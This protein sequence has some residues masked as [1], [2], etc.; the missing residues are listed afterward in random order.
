MS[1]FFQ[2]A[3]M[4][5]ELSP[6]IKGRVDIDQYYKGMQTAENV[7][8]VP[9][10]GLKRRPGTQH[11]DVAEK[12][13]SP[14]VGT[15][16]ITL[17]NGGTAA[18][19][20]D[21][22]P[23]TQSVTTTPVGNLGTSG[24]SDYVVALYNLSS[25]SSRG[26]FVEIKDIKL[27]GT[28]T[29]VFKL[30]ISTDNVSYSTSKTLTVTE[31]P[32]SIKA[33]VSDTGDVKY[34]RIIRTGDTGN[35]AGLQVS[36]SEFNVLFPT[37]TASIAKTFDLS[38]ESDRHYLGVLT[39]GFDTFNFTITTG[40]P[41]VGNTYTVNSATYRVLSFVSGVAKT[42]RTIGTNAPPT[43]GTLAG[44]PTLTYSAVSHSD[45]FG[46]MSFYRVNDTMKLAPPNSISIT[47]FLTTPFASSEV[48]DVR[49]VQTE[50]VMLMFHMEHFPKRIINT[51]E[52]AFVIDSI[53][54]LNI[55]QFDFNDALS[56][57][58]TAA[59]QV[60]TFPNS[61]TTGVQIGD[62]FQIDVEGVLSKNISFAGDS[63]A[64]EQSSTI[65]NIR[66]NLQDMPI[67]GDDGIVV[68]RTG[69]LEYTITLDG[70]SSGTYEL[71]TGF[72][73]SGK[74]TDAIT[75]TRSA[76]G[77]PRSE[78]VWSDT[79]GYPRTATFFQGRL[80]FGGTKSKR[81]SV[82]A[83]RA[84][85][86]FDFFTEEG[87]D[88]EGIFVTISSRNL[89]EI[90]DINPDRGLQ[91][92]TSGAEFLLTGNTP[93][94]VSIKAQTQH[95]SKFLEAKSLDGAT[96]FID[97]NGK[98]L[99]QYLYNYNE[100][101][102]NSVDI[103]VL[104]SHLIDNP[105]DVGVLSGSTTEDANYVV[106]I[107][108]DGSAAILNTLRSQDINGFT[109]WTNGSTGTVYPLN[110]ISVSTVH[111]DLFFVN[112]RTTDTTTTYTIERWDQ[113]YLLDS[114][115]KL[116]SQTSIVG[117]E[118]ILS[119]AHLTGFTVSLVARGNV[120]PNKTVAA[121]SGTNQN[122]KITLSDSEKAF[123]IAG[124]TSGGT[125]NVQVGFNFQPKMKSMPLNTTAG[126]IA[127]QNQ[128]RDKK[129]T[130]MNLRVLDSAGVVIDGNTVPTLEFGTASSTP[131]NSDLSPFTGVIQDNNGGNGWNIEVVPEITVPN[132]MPFHIQAIEYE[133]QSS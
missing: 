67:F 6:L 51:D 45:S 17:P 132:P 91:I 83:S 89:T 24:Q 36:I 97:K 100:D 2:S 21:F 4:S 115:I 128:M 65:E 96:L 101:A 117:N 79:R 47:E 23:S 8:I 52:N 74:A 68:T 122:G 15:S 49:D 120:L 76:A 80:W 62:R 48:Q 133:V 106:V 99:R 75:F 126:N 92:F 94:T 107:N 18:N 125:M 113:T 35:L 84:G 111:N 34:F 57:I 124:D 63:N 16:F 86:F 27:S 38:I 37:T 56:P 58:P 123:I 98:T 61:G 60:M 103:S 39:G 82:F 118:L 112:K 3:F 41:T 19:I 26:K 14:F 20:N 87:D 59:I 93:A 69:A 22:T 29:G 40:T 131:L 54:F 46:N 33:R 104:S 77:V 32:Q 110:I 55:P 7:V 28:G 42:E 114:G 78:D 11:I 102:Y 30:Q 25:E 119:S 13:F 127:G 81:Q 129:I 12:I 43:S 90:V 64:N 73:T 108:E 85:S 44:T 66:K 5:G 72:F 130:R 105:A 95:G 1:K 70:N 53:P 9:Q 10:G 71:F 121:T 31:N 116:L 50:N 109:K 88:D